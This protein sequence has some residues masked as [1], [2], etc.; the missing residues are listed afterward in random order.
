MMIDI[1]LFP[2]SRTSRQAVLND[3]FRQ[4][5]GNQGAWSLDGVI[6]ALPKDE[7]EHILHLI[8]SYDRFTDDNNYNH[9]RSFG[10]LFPDSTNTWTPSTRRE[11]GFLVPAILWSI[12]TESLDGLRLSPDPANPNVTRRILSV[13]YEPADDDVE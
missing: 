13:K 6:S 1:D 4:S 12:R 2:S 3:Q 7:L 10:R 5:S 8:R 9:L 11:M